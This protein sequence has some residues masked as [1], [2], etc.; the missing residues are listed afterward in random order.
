M[1][2]A[3]TFHNRTFPNQEQGEVLKKC[4][5]KLKKRII[6]IDKAKLEENKRL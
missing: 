1:M 6:S 3:R 4:K 5:K 2:K